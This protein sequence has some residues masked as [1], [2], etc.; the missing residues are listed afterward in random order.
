MDVNVKIENS[1]MN[2]I[3]RN[4]SRLSHPGEFLVLS[5]HSLMNALM[6][7]PEEY[8]RMFLLEGGF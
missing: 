7:W 4:G 6:N 2:G 8:Q 3:G 1:Y 5:S